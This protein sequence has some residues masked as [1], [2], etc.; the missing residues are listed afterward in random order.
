MKKS[1]LLFLMIFVCVMALTAPA[2][3]CGG[4]SVLT[5]V[6]NSGVDI[7][8]KNVEFY[9][10]TNLEFPEVTLADKMNASV[11][12]GLLKPGMM[13]VIDGIIHPVTITPDERNPIGRTGSPFKIWIKLIAGQKA[14]RGNFVATV[15]KTPMLDSDNW[16][17]T[18]KAR[19]P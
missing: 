1:C 19:K 10:D 7:T 13:I 18:F 5:I 11:N 6:N 15:T 17:I 2:A 4:I 12:S 3:L 8:I 9:N 14:I 16:H